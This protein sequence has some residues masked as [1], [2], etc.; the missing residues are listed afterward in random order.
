MAFESAKKIIEFGS[1]AWYNA[2]SVLPNH[3]AA[4]N[5]GCQMVDFQTK[6]ATF[7]TFWKA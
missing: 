7:G 4:A 5:Q 1:T 3:N 6:N 2:I